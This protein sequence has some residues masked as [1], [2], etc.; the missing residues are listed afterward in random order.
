MEIVALEEA[1]ADE[2]DFLYSLQQNQSIPL[3]L[4]VSKCKNLTKEQADS[5]QATTEN[6]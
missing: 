1:L 5:I 4:K 2:R 6:I 3:N